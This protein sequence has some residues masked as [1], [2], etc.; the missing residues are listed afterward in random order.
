MDKK[1]VINH[2]IEYLTEEL[3]SE[4]SAE[5]KKEIE[6]L[7]LMYRFLPSRNYTAEDVIIPSTLVTLRTGIMT[8][9]YF[10]VPQGGGLITQIDG[11]PL[12]VITPNSPLGES[13]MGKKMGE[14][15]KIEIRGTNR[16]YEIVA[17][18]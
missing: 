10:I 15:F 18:G 14:I 9:Y 8:A 1:R 4:E 2:L 6:A 11:R 16:E 12:Q 5:K 3:N 17:I 13:L 7:L